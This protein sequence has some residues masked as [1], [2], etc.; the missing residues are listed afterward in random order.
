M[1]INGAGTVQSAEP[2]KAGPNLTDVPEN[3]EITLP[4]IIGNNMVLQRD[5][6]LRIW[7]QCAQDG[8]VTVMINEQVYYGECTEGRF[9]VKI[10]PLEVGGPYEIVIGNDNGKVVLDN[11]LA[12]DVFLASGQSNMA[13]TM[14]QANRIGEDIK[15]ENAMLRF[16]QPTPTTSS[17][18]L[19]ET[20]DFW[21]N[22]DSLSLPVLSAVAYYFG[23]TLQEQ[24]GIPI[25]IVVA[26]DGG[27]IVSAWTPAEEVAQMPTVYQDSTKPMFTPSVYYNA[28]IH[29]L[30][31]VK[32]KG[33][34]WYQGENQPQQYDEMLTLLIQG[35][36]RIF[37]DERLHFTIVQLPRWGQ[38]DAEG[39]Y[40][41]REHQK[42]VAAR[43]PHVT[44]SVNIDLGDRDDL[45]PADKKPVG[46]RAA[47]ATMESLYGEAGIWRGPALSGYTVNGNKFILSF[48]HRGSG[49][50]LAPDAGGFEIADERGQYQRAHAE[51]QGETVVI[52]NDTID[53]PAAVRYAYG[54]FP[55]VSLYNKEGFPAEQFKIT[56]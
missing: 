4:G 28:M 34:L 41:S 47:F 26:A 27:T 15:A 30:K 7:G 23:Q 35:W 10:D 17:T 21:M 12:G 37:A 19:D 42:A 22:T 55:D 16:Y 29:P 38:G 18:P 54:S 24:H 51:I 53:H 5:T 56:K 1:G 40:I 6:P 25:G 9:D 32:F 33:V 14:E 31:K 52:W 8:P 43:M 2:G 46:M 45:H 13:M 3:N 39:W 20:N 36:R 11:V 49:L 44:Y 48:D 50:W